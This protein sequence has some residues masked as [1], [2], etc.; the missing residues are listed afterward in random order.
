[1]PD[2]SRGLSRPAVSTEDDL[3]EWA[4]DMDRSALDRR[5]KREREALIQE[6]RDNQ[7]IGSNNTF[8]GSTKFVNWMLSVSTVLLT[9][10]IVGLVVLYGQV[11]SINSK[12]DLIITG[13]IK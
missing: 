12:V 9:T 2:A 11:Q 13:H 1:M 6:I 4:T 7:G 10:A 8:N 3:R 5:F